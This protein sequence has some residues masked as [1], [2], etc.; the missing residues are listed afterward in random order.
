MFMNLKACGSQ[1]VWTAVMVSACAS[2]PTG[3]YL[4]FR[5]PMTNVVVAELAFPS[6]EGCAFVLRGM[7]AGDD[8]ARMIA[9]I[10]A[11]SPTSAFGSL[12][13][14]ATLRDTT[15]GYLFDLETLDLARCETA[16]AAF[17]RDTVGTFEK[18]SGCRN[19]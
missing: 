15:G 12:G 17:L 10:G 19:R 8:K 18:A 16:L 4:Q 3:R 5:S 13:A 11:C 1:I 2:A 14:H 9:T 7:G 6:A